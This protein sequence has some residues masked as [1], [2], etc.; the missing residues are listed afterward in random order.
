ME[1]KNLWRVSAP[2]TGAPNKIME[3]QAQNLTEATEGLVIGEVNTQ[4]PSFVSSLLLKKISPITNDPNILE[5]TFHATVPNLNYKL[6]IMKITFSVFEFYPLILNDFINDQEY[7]VN[8]ED[9]FKNKLEEI[10]PS[11]NMTKVINNLMVQATIKAGE[12]N[13]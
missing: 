2:T 5:C 6:Q 3:T 10:I 4:K 7:E 12:S 11:P 8:G 13:K 9:D 1:L